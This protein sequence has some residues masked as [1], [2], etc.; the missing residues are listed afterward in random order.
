[1]EIIF[2][3]LF[4]LTTCAGAGASILLMTKNKQMKKAL[5]DTKTIELSEE[6]AI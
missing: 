1:M 5:S 6:E 3:I 2:I 4:V